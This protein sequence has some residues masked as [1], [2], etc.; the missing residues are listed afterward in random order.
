[1]YRLETRGQ[2]LSAGIVEFLQPDGMAVIEWAERLL[3]SGHPTSNIQHPTSN[4]EDNVRR[5]RIEVLNGSE[6][7][8]VYD[9]FGA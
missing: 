6:R 8:I 4:L 1:L 7:K 9:D 5:V 2:I 3:G